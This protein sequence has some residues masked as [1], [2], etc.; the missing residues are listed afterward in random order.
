[1]KIVIRHVPYHYDIQGKGEP[2]LMLHGF[3]GSLKTWHPV[4]SGLRDRFQL[5]MVDLL[6]HGKTGCPANPERYAMHE[7]ARDLAVL[8]DQL[9]LNRI[10]LSGYSMG[11]RL[12]LGFACLYPERVRS[13]ILES[14]SPGLQEEEE[15][16]R[17][18]I[19]DRALAEKIRE[20]GIRS[21][22]DDWED[23]PLFH[24]QKRLPHPVSQAI[25]E[26]RL[27]NH[28]EGLAGSL[29]GMG[30]GTQP[31]WWDRLSSLNI[32]VLLITGGLDEKF[33]KTAG[34]MRRLLPHAT[35]QQVPGSGHN[36]HLEKSQ[37][38]TEIVRSFL[39]N[40]SDQSK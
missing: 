15:R 11:G 28:E 8:L 21:F 1:M 32:P 30:T 27:A 39:I 20:K 19:H 2:L 26:E 6:G 23:I 29:L 22:V 10:Y 3:T 37:A 36:V 33:C 7:A 17:R 38:F 16:R 24:S 18:R 40:Q 13:L 14:A 34:D 12:A 9:D 4:A 35:W 31:A 5:I 25:R